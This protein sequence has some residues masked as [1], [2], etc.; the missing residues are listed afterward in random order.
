MLFVN[1]DGWCLFHETDKFF[2]ASL[3][4]TSCFFS[5]SSYFDTIVGLLEQIYKFLQWHFDTLALSLLLSFELGV[6]C[7]KAYCWLGLIFCAS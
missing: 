1:I 7:F 2:K 6:N 3:Q 5:C 4:N